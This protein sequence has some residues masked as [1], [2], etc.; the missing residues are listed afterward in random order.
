ML[1]ANKTAIIVGGARGMGGAI[2]LKFADEG[3]SSVIADVLDGP[4][5]S[6]ASEIKKKGR[7]SIFIH[8]D[9]SDSRQVKEMVNQSIAKFGKIDILV[10]T[11]GVGTNPTRL[12]ELTDDKWDK[13]MDINCK[14]TFLCIQAV[15]PHMINNKSGNII[16]IVS[17][18]ALG[19]SPVN[20]HYH[21]SKA[22]QL[23]V[24][25]SAAALLAPY[26]VRVNVI[27]PG[28]VLTDMSAVFSG[29]GVKDVVAHQTGM[30]QHGVPLRRM[31]T[32]EDIAKAALFLASDESSYITGDEI[33]VS[34]GSGLISSSGPRH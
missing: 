12:E 33:C 23:S 25:R 24:A 8:C 14:G 30:A 32:T 18:A 9:V 16:C 34:G 29:P 27:H 3:C 26:D 11:A 28:M 13:V 15:A 7:E 10:V 22:A 1:L 5:A 6:T 2:A 21:A 20:W 4:G 19:G 17:V 31:G